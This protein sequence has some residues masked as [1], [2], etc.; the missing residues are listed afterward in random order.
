MIYIFRDI[1][2]PSIEKLDIITKLFNSQ[3]KVRDI[4]DG[5]YPFKYLLSEYIISQSSANFQDN[6]QD[7]MHYDEIKNDFTKLLKIIF[8]AC[9][10]KIKKDYEI[11]IFSLNRYTYVDPIHSAQYSDYLFGNI[12]NELN[13]NLPNKSKI[14]ITTDY[15][16]QSELN[17]ENI[18]LYQSISILDILKAFYKSLYYKFIWKNEFC[19]LN[20]RIE[21]IDKYYYK[22]YSSFFFLRTLFI[23]LLKNI[24]IKKIINDLK[25]KLILGNDDLIFLRPNSILDK[26][27]KLYIVQS[28]ITTISKEKTICILMKN[29]KMNAMKSDK[30]FVTGN[31]FKELKVIA[32]TSK[33][34]IIVGQTRY[35]SLYN[36]Q[37]ECDRKSILRKIGLS[38]RKK[39]IIWTTTTNDNSYTE[40]VEYIKTL[41]NIVNKYGY[42]LII[43]PHP[44]ESIQCINM[45]QKN[46]PKNSIII[47]DKEI[48]IF[49][50]IF[51]SDLLI[52]KFS[53]TAI[54]AVL[55][56]KPV[57]VMNFSKMEDQIN[58]ITEGIAI[59]AYNPVELEDV[60]NKLIN[61]PSILS[62]N[63]MEFIKRNMYALD[64]RAT[65]RILKNILGI[66]I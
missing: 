25:P 61:N 54:E 18:P 66:E 47:K 63:R 58:Y 52:T 65:S 19:N 43:K 44:G 30:F 28:A 23:Y 11:L 22:I 31:Y 35:D 29:F 42:Q 55:L 4:T 24:A 33:E 26:G 38:D 9:K 16:I 56:N 3:F 32:G 5:A 39:I 6:Y 49:S 15:K 40:N 64:G 14:L 7:H 50:L 1:Y 27:I 46:K 20:K 12:I 59:G 37:K 36:L 21:E 10:S 2:N 45:Y 60:I 51:V 53:T 41:Y 34:I 48:D 57:I 62:T 17:I 13:K 8:L